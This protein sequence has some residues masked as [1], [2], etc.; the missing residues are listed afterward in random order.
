[1]ADDSVLSGNHFG[2]D[3]FRSSIHNMLDYEDL[4]DAALDSL[5]IVATAIAISFPVGRLGRKLRLVTDIQVHQL[6]I[7]EEITHNSMILR[8]NAARR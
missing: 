6:Q 1:M 8:L 3:L 7:L 2:D 5:A 4:D